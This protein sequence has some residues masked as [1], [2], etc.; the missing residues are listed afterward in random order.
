[1]NPG[2]ILFAE[3]KGSYFIKMIGEIRLTL[4]PALELF[5]DQILA[6]TNFHSIVFDLSSAD[7]ID[8]TSLGLLAKLSIQAKKR[9]NV[10]P[11]IVSPKHD[12]TQ[13]LHSMGFEQFFMVIEQFKSPTNFTMKELPC[14]A[15]STSEQ[16][17]HERVLDAH[18]VLMS[19]NDDNRKAFSDLVAQLEQNS[20]YTPLQN[21]HRSSSALQKISGA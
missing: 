7:T 20:H 3:S 19:L 11:A 17:I 21:Q 12:T 8:S 2:K 1:M 14:D 18:R 4:C 10:V 9:Y 6:K 13:I 16:I 5:L 15:N